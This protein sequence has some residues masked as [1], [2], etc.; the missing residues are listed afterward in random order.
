LRNEKFRK[1][2]LHLHDDF[3]VIFGAE[4]ITQPITA[5]AERPSRDMYN[6]S[7]SKNTKI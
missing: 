7:A 5:A 3:E 4:L 1:R 6:I 2:H